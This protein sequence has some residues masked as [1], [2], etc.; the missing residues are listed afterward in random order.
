M[1]KTIVGRI[2]LWQIGVSLA[3]ATAFFFVWDVRN[4]LAALAGGGINVIASGYFALRLFSPSPGAP[5][6]QL[7]SALVRGEAMKWVVTI[8]LFIV[9]IRYF[10]EQFVALILTYMAATSIYWFSLLWGDSESTPI[11]KRKQK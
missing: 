8:A 9:A 11:D 7:L 3:A 6:D 2:L 1:T 10:H 5:P 4:A